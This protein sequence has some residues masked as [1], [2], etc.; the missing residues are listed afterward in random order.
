MQ[1]VE[2]VKCGGICKMWCAR[3]GGSMHKC[4]VV[5]MKCGVMWYV[6][7][8]KMGCSARCDVMW[9]IW[10]DLKYSIAKWKSAV[11]GTGLIW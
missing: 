10:C 8:V 11:R 4:G 9:P 3:C 2:H 7:N 6:S 5:Y 1:D